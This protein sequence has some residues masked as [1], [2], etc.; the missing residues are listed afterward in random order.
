MSKRCQKER[1][2]EEQDLG[3]PK[4]KAEEPEDN[5]ERDQRKEAQKTTAVQKEEIESNS[6]NQ[7]EKPNEEEE[8]IEEP[9]IDLPKLP[10]KRTVKWEKR[11]SER[12][13]K[14]PTDE[15]TT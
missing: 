15:E 12:I 11:S 6:H 3:K 7:S 8:T 4:S 10:V 14:N 1:G 2:L 13:T 5:E 9:V